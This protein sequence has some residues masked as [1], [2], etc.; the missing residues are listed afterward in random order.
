M[1]PNGHELKPGRKFCTVCGAP[2]VNAPGVQTTFV[3]PPKKSRAGLVVVAALATI[4]LAATA[5]FTRGFGI[6]DR[7]GDI[8]AA[9]TQALTTA[10][11]PTAVM[12]NV[13]ETEIVAPE[14][15]VTEVN[16]EW[17]YFPNGDW[18]ADNDRFTNTEHWYGGLIDGEYVLTSAGLFRAD[19][20]NTPIGWFPGGPLNQFENVNWVSGYCGALL[21]QGTMP[22]G[23]TLIKRFDP[24]TGAELWQFATEPQLN[25]YCSTAGYVV[26]FASDGSGS[27]A[28]HSVVTGAPVR[29]FSVWS[30]QLIAEFGF[31]DRFEDGNGWTRSD[32]NNF[33]GAN[34]CLRVVDDTRQLV[35][36]DAD[37]N[38][39]DSWNLGDLRVDSGSEFFASPEGVLVRTNSRHQA[40]ELL[41]LPNSLLQI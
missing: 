21:I 19:D 11:Q 20:P 2:A 5:V 8:V 4:A 41:L 31:N 37:G 15:T 22:S 9:E 12:E 14:E 3:I 10:E 7:P 17:I 1:C 6:L 29:E 18:S 36:L 30:D 24:A 33:C 35:L 16:N 40:S 23:E 38:P 32:E 13:L 28:V 25:G 27:G 34:R 26:E 39:L